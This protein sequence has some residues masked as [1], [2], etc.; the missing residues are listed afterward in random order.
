LHHSATANEYCP[1]SSAALC[2]ALATQSPVAAGYPG[3][4]IHLLLRLVTARMAEG[5]R[6][7]NLFGRATSEFAIDRPE[8]RTGSAGS[9]R[10]RRPMS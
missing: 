1:S 7:S 3:R 6:S 10:R 9:K 2:L 5:V 8:I 4:P